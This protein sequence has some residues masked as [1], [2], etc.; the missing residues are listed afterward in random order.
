MLPVSR[1]TVGDWPK[2]RS[3]RVCSAWHQQRRFYSWSEQSCWWSSENRQLSCLVPHVVDREVWF[4]RRTMG[5]A[6]PEGSHTNQLLIYRT[7]LLSS[8][9]PHKQY[10]PIAR[11]YLLT[12]ALMWTLNFT[13]CTGGRIIIDL[14]PRFQ[15][16][17]VSWSCHILK[18]WECG[19]SDHKIDFLIQGE[20]IVA[21]CLQLC[22]VC[23]SIS[24]DTSTMVE[25][26]SPRISTEQ[27]SLSSPSPS[28][29]LSLLSSIF[30]YHLKGY[31]TTQPT[32][33]K[34]WRRNP[35]GASIEN[36]R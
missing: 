9:M 27:H 36:N 32:A 7:A 2:S 11:Y 8:L 22:V 26:R 5:Y 24:E 19:Y 33:H 28:F 4:Y 18:R 20:P 21:N 35:Q 34:L 16:R 29:T 31:L 6:L 1:K 10:T 14:V 13:N 25:A 17:T 15:V 12:R 3:W 23:L 30:L